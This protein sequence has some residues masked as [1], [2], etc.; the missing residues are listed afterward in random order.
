MTR[1]YMGTGIVEMIF[2]HIKF[3]TLFY[4]LAGL[5][6]TV[7][8]RHRPLKHSELMLSVIDV[9][10]FS[11]AQSDSGRGAVGAINPYYSFLNHSCESNTNCSTS[12]LLACEDMSQKYMYAKKKIKK[13]GEITITYWPFKEARMHPRSSTTANFKTSSRKHY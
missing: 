9:D 10:C 13:G 2:E 6:R 8:S 4:C 5:F 1:R 3:T 7:V 12:L 11:N